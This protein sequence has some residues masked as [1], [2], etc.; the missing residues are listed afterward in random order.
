MPTFNYTSGNTANLTGGGPASMTDIQGPFTDLRSAVNGNLDETNVPNL[1]AAFTTYKTITIGFAAVSFAAAS[2]GIYAVQYGPPTATDVGFGTA[3]AA[4]WLVL[5]YLD[6]ADFNANARTTKLRLR[7]AAVPSIAPAMTFTVGLYPVSSYTAPGGGVHPRVNITAG[8]A[9]TGSTVAIASPAN[10][11]L[12]VATSGDF[13]F[14][15]AGAYAIG[16]LTSAVPAANSV[17]DFAVTV[18]MRQA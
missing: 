9:L 1:S 17:T 12:T 14:P 5:L 7:V 11:A 13:N 8:T 16:I 4:P 3:A 10:A 2:G 18:Q 6:P 15:A